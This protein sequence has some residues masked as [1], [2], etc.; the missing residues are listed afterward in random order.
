MFKWF[1]KIKNE[2]IETF[3]TVTLHTSGMRHVTDDE[4]VYKDGKA[5]VSKYGIGYENGEHIRILQKRAVCDA[6]VALKLLNDCQVASWDGFYGPH[7]KHIRDGTM[8]N[9]KAV[10]NGKEISARGSQNF[11][12]HYRDFT[13]GLYEIYEKYKEDT[14]NV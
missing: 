6:G 3:E 11:P 7:P 8:F 13:D 1:Q 4:I 10:V 2:K 14:E 5:E 12:R 9:F